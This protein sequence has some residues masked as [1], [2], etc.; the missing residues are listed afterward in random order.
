MN[1]NTAHICTFEAQYLELKEGPRKITPLQWPVLDRTVQTI[2]I[3][4]GK[5]AYSGTNANLMRLAIEFEERVLGRVICHSLGFRYQSRSGP[6]ISRFSEAGANRLRV[7]PS[8]TLM[9][10]AA[11][12][13][14]VTVLQRLRKHQALSI[15]TVPKRVR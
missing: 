11:R 6:P 9:A 1:Q 10:G 7:G 3:S 14:P 4:A 12:F 2:R 13:A 8:G 15:R 5:W